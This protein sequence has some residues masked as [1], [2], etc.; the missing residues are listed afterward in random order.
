MRI[1]VDEYYNRFLEVELGE[2]LE[3]FKNDLLRR[4]S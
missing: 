3:E 1:T 2:D 4:A